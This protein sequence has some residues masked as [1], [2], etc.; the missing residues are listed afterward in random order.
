LPTDFPKMTGGL[1]PHLFDADLGAAHRRG[2]FSA[3]AILVRL[4]CIDGE[5][6]RVVHMP[7][8][9]ARGPAVHERYERQHEQASGADPDTEQHE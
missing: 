1:G 7:R 4:D 8:R 5:R 6:R 9:D 2:E 3:Q